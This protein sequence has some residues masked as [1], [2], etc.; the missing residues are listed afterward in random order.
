MAT[1]KAAPAVRTGVSF[2]AASAAVEPEPE[3]GVRK[4]T[5]FE[6]SHNDWIHPQRM[7]AA[8]LLAAER[9][10][11]RCLGAGPGAHVPIQGQG[12]VA[13]VLQVGRAPHHVRAG[14]AAPWLR[15]PTA[16]PCRGARSVTFSPTTTPD[17][18]M[19]I[20]GYGNGDV[21]TFDLASGVRPAPTADK[22]PAG[23]PRRRGSDGRVSVASAIC[24]LCRRP[25]CWARRTSGPARP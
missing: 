12:R 19:V 7:S 21:Y 22:T 6:P 2:P 9:L 15:A 1:R 18:G 13:W 8:R 5:S 11:R 25:R 10:K 20:A 3:A 14:A 4:A 24:H 16:A 23:R 17:K